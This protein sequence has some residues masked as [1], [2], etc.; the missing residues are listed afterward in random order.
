MRVVDL[1]FFIAEH[2]DHHI[3]HVSTLLRKPDLG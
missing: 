3:A 1:L 2:D